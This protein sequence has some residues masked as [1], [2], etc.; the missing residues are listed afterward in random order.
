MYMRRYCVIDKLI[1]TENLVSSY[2]LP[3]TL[4]NQLKRRTVF[5]LNLRLNTVLT[6][7]EVSLI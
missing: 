3:F 5:Q 2:E 7:H 1:I 6:R 4:D